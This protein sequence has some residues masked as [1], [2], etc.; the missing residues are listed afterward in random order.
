MIQMKLSFLWSDGLTACILLCPQLVNEHPYAQEVY[1]LCHDEE[2]VVVLYHQPQQEEKLDVR[3]SFQDPSARG[4]ELLHLWASAVDQHGITHMGMQ[5][6]ISKL[7]INPHMAWPY[8][9]N[10]SFPTAFPAAN[11]SRKTTTMPG[12]Q[13]QDAPL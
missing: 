8:V 5:N 7:T 3:H 13:A 9:F 2:V 6:L 11:F 4:R 1:H 12:V 10:S